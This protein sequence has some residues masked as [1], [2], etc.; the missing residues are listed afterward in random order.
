MTNYAQNNFND[1]P[2][3]QKAESRKPICIVTGIVFVLMIVA[4]K[5]AIG[6]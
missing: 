6:G 4:F 2:I 5:H 1:S 3:A